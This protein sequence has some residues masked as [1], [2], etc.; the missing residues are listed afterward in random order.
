MGR[1]F[2]EQAINKAHEQGFDKFKAIVLL[3][4]R[5]RQKQKAVQGVKYL[6]EE[7]QQ[8]AKAQSKFT[9]Q[10][11]KELTHDE[12]NLKEFYEHLTNPPQED[13]A[14]TTKIE[15]EPKKE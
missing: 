4:Q 3:A 9:V 2:H 13:I 11:I 5:A 10:A 15:D 6:S 14:P 1:I 8:W 7:Q 12:L